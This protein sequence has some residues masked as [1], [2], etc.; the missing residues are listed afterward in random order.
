MPMSAF[1]KQHAPIVFSDVSSE[2]ELSQS[3]L[4]ASRTFTSTA[5]KSSVKHVSSV[6]KKAAG[7][8]HIKAAAT[9]SLI[10]QPDISDEESE[11]END[12]LEQIQVLLQ[13][14]KNQAEKKDAARKKRIR[15]QFEAH[16][17]EAKQ[18]YAAEVEEI[19]DAF[20]KEAQNMLKTMKAEAKRLDKEEAKAL[21]R[22]HE[23]L[24]ELEA[25]CEKVKGQAVSVNET[26]ETA[27]GVCDHLLQDLADKLTKIVR[28]TETDLQ[29]VKAQRVSFKKVDELLVSMAAAY[30]DD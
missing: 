6:T 8:T 11:H 29:A 12:L 28:G 16:V 5:T 21:Q 3:S 1:Y 14:Q 20:Q 22:Q 24:A 2:N 9:P 27:S 7:G 25:L 26:K 15:E 23:Y 17:Q 19:H 18:K 30:E 13:Q 10:S 4:Q